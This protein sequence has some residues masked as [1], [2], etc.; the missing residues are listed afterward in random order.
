MGLLWPFQKWIVDTY[1]G[2]GRTSAKHAGIFGKPETR[3]CV[4]F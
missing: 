1:L 2:C 4:S 3:L